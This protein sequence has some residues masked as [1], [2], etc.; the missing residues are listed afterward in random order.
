[1][2]LRELLA[3]F[4]RERNPGPFA[5]PDIDHHPGSATGPHLVFGFLVHGNE[6]GTLPAALRI[7]NELRRGSLVAPGPV[8]LF[9]GNRAAALA[10][11][12]FLEEDLNRVFTFDRKADCLERRRAEELRPV[13]DVADFFLDLHQTQTPTA[14]P[15]WTFPWDPDFDA[16]ARA[17]AV[18]EVGLTR[19]GGQVFSP[20]LCCADEYV[21]ARGKPGITVEVGF[22]GLDEEQSERTYAA[23]RATLD[24]FSALGRGRTLAEVAAEKPPLTY[25]QTAHIVIAER[26][27]Y[28]LRPGYQNWS[29]V[30][31]G[32]VLSAEG[33]PL[34]VSPMDGVVL[35]PKY[36]KPGQSPPRELMRIAARGAPA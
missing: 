33:T 25:Y 11:E 10:D 14:R 9:V 19:P 12:R 5:G 32:E 18:A 1:M 26:E 21:R 7:G 3:R 4:E 15:F 34:L 13:L 24:L 36:P 27:N 35:F 31:A 6:C 20:G 17:L 28:A 8:T 16:Y 22:R 30:T 23:V 29:E 2:D